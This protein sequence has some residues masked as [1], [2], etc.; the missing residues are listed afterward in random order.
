MRNF[1][2][3]FKKSLKNRCKSY[4]YK[5]RK[6]AKKHYTEI[7]QLLAHKSFYSDNNEKNLC[8]ATCVHP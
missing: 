5:S 1:M 3:F 2:H 8:A 6:E 4:R 7:L